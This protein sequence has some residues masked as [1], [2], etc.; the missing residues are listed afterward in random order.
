MDEQQT[1]AA[2]SQTLELEGWTVPCDDATLLLREIA[3]WEAA[4]DEDALRIEKML[5][6]ME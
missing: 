3:A 1:A 5:A 2:T 6:E 4:S